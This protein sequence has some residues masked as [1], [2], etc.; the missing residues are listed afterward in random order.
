MDCKYLFPIW[1]RMAVVS[2]ISKLTIKTSILCTNQEKCQRRWTINIWM[3]QIR[4]VSGSGKPQKTKVGNHMG[5]SIEK[6]LAWRY[7]YCALPFF[8]RHFLNAA[9]CVSLCV[10][11]AVKARLYLFKTLVLKTGAIITFP[12]EC[13]MQMSKQNIIVWHS[14]SVSYIVCWCIYTTARHLH[15]IS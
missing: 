9:P 11:S 13:W 4:M 14:S 6:R 1:K 12:I 2:D 15:S 8:R 7:I 10:C 3:R 5:L